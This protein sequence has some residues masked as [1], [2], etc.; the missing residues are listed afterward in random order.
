MQ[1]PGK[2]LEKTVTRGCTEGSRPRG[3]KKRTGTNEVLTKDQKERVTC[4]KTFKG[5]AGSMTAQSSFLSINI[6]SRE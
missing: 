1:H 5:S 4:H 2:C 3:R 6:R